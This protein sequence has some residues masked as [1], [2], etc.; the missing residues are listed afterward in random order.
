MH[1]LT[2][3]YVDDPGSEEKS[4]R[5]RVDVEQISI[6]GPQDGE[7]AWPEPHRRLF[8]CG[9]SDPAPDGGQLGVEEAAR[10]IFSNL[11]PRAFRRQAQPMEIE[12]SVNLVKMAVDQ[13]ESFE[14]GVA[15]GLQSVLVSPHFLFRVERSLPAENPGT[16]D[17]QEAENLADLALASRLSYF[18]WSSMPDEAL[19]QA[20]NQGQLSDP[21]VLQAQVERMLAD[22]KSQALVSRFF[23][24]FLGLGGLNEASPDPRQFPQWNPKLRDA[25]RHETE[26][27]CQEILKQDLPLST[28]LDADFS[29]VNPRLAELYGMEFDG[30]DPRELYRSGPR[31]SSRCRQRRA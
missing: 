4:Y 21:A 8:I 3:F 20:A 26:L 1:E 18:L 16:P 28:L 25:L 11:I 19:R 24:Q 10:R 6:Q 31:L 14:Q 5:R 23:G 17:G 9:P 22:P 7:P 2:L 30:R 15:Y 12:R 13:G 29:F 27:F